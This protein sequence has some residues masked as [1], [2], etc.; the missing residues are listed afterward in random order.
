MTLISKEDA[1]E[2][3]MSAD[4]KDR[5]YH[6]YKHIA[7]K[8]LEEIPSALTEKI[9]IKFLQDSGW[10][11]NHDKEIGNPSML[12]RCKDCRFAEKGTNLSVEETDE[13][14]PRNYIDWIKCRNYDIHKGFARYVG[15]DDYCSWGE[16]KGGDEV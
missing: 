11:P 9:A 3:V 12:V 2:A 16:R 8:V 1:I 13:G 6:Y 7:V 10:I 5:E 15:D 14:T 4:P